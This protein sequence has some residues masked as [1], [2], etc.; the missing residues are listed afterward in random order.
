MRALALIALPL[1]L[2]ACESAPVYNEPAPKLVQVYNR[3]WAVTQVADA[4]LTFRAIRDHNNNDPFGPPA[5]LKSV[6]A[7]RAIETATN[8]R[9]IRSSM[10][11]N[12]SDFFYTQ[13]TCP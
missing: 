10:Y 3:T 11:R 8:C 4:P 1:L 5:K 7:I 6:Q 13:V 9:V 2:A 12:V